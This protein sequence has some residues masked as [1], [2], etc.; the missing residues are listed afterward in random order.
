M[1]Y[2]AFNIIKRELNYKNIFNT[3]KE[4]IKLLKFFIFIYE[5]L[6]LKLLNVIY[7]IFIW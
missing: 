2:L 5:Y 1:N 3:K 7:C 4:K 6:I